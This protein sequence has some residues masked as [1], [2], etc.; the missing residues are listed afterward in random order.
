M[1]DINAIKTHEDPRKFLTNW[2]EGCTEGYLLKDL[3]LLAI[4]GMKDPL[5]P[6]VIDAIK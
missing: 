6:D 3:T 4:A 1:N 2:L 5:R